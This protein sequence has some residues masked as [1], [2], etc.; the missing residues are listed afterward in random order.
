MSEKINNLVAG[1]SAGL[2]EAIITWPSEN[3]KTQMQFFNQ[4]LSFMQ[5]ASNIYGNLGFK[6]FYRG[7]TPVLAFNIPK[8]ALR[9]Y[10]YEYFSKKMVNCDKNLRTISSGFLAG[11]VESTF[12]T[13]PSETIKTKMIKNPSLTVWQTINK[14]GLYQGYIPT[15]ARQ[16]LNQA[17]RFFFY[18]HYKEWVEKKGKFTNLNSFIGGVG[19]GCFSVVVSTPADVLKT[20]MQEG[21][22]HK[23]NFL[24]KHIYKENGILGFWRGSLARLLRVAPGQGVMFL[25]YE[26]VNKLLKKI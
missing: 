14:G 18:Q 3:I 1:S 7:I 21:E 26:Y 5:T 19:A 12:I 4:R 9:F 20:Q 6:G 11:F 15:V 10:S 17:S 8:V 2:L 24:I 22:K 16:S 25:T 13:V 23:I